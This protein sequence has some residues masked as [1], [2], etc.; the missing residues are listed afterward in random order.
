[1]SDHN[2]CRVRC[3]NFCGIFLTTFM[4]H[5]IPVTPLQPAARQPELRLQQFVIRQRFQ[6][7]QRLTVHLIRAIRLRDC[8][9]LS[10]QTLYLHCFNSV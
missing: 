8:V 7:V 5:N 3:R 10:E 6:I 2:L 4:Y 1:M 9:I